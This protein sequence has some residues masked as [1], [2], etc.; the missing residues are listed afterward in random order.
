MIYSS[1][2]RKDRQSVVTSMDHCGQ[3]CAAMRG[4]PDHRVL[5]PR[6][7]SEKPGARVCMDVMETEHPKLLLVYV[8]GK[9]VGACLPRAHVRLRVRK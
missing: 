4:P 9:N 2:T 8:A 7:R 5:N 1:V 6:S 3:C